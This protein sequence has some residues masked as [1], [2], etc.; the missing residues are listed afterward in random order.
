MVGGDGGSVPYRL[1]AA[2]VRW[3]GASPGFWEKTKRALGLDDKGLRQRPGDDFRRFMAPYAGPELPLS[4]GATCRTVFGVERRGMGY[5]QPTGH[6]LAGATLAQVHEYPWP[7]PA[8][9]DVSGV[10]AEAE[11][12]GGQYAILGGERTWTMTS[13]SPGC[14]EPEGGMGWARQDCLAHTVSTAR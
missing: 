3:C 9:T 6:P 7:D 2:G 10:R 8:W 1:S 5:G 13:P 12:W 4:Q 11:A 14:S